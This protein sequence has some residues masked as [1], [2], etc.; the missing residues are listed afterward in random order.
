MITT[1]IITPVWNRADLTSQYLYDHFG[2]YANR[3]DTEWII[4]DNGSTDETPQSLDYWQRMIGDRL[5]VIRNEENLGYSKANNQ[6]IAIARGDIFAFLNNDIV[7]TGDYL[8]PL[9]KAVAENPRAIVGAQLL[10]AN[11]GWN[12]FGDEIIPYLVGWCF[13][14][15]RALFEDIGGFDERYSFDYEDSDLC[16]AAVEKGYELREIP[17]P[18]HHLGGQSGKLLP[19]REAITKVNRGRFAE[20]WGLTL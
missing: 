13:A 20:K 18:I 4:I 5:T 12:R 9:E 6:G 10:T 17:L 16:K 1:S 14:M 7:I 2:R 8:T 3:K 19:D 15:H 11:T